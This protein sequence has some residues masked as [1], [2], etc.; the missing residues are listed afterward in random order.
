MF[1][2][3]SIHI[4]FLNNYKADTTHMTLCDRYDR[5][6]TIPTSATILPAD[7]LN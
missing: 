6:K 1:N 3:H 2:N 7:F 5:L 4:K